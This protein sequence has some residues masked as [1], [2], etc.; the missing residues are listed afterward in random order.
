M[1][2]FTLYV[3]GFLVL[4]AGLGYGAYL[5]H[6]PQTWIGVGALVL[7]GFGIMSA[8][9]RTKTKDPPADTPTVEIDHR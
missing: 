8:V 7:I 6:V 1:S 2:A 4:L 5:L 9:G 3:L